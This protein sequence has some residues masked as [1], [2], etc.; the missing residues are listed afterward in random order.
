MSFLSNL[1]SYGEQQI[2][3]VKTS[4]SK[5]KPNHVVSNTFE[6]KNIT[7]EMIDYVN[8]KEQLLPTERI[9]LLYSY[10]QKFNADDTLVGITN[11][12]IIKIDKDSV[13]IIFRS[14][15]GGFR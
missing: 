7:K 12:R 1:K 4:I 10:T 11:Y 6:E 2:N 5:N 14:V 15:I 8:T 13:S 3:V 9:L